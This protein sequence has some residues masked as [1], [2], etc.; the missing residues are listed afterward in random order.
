MKSVTVRVADVLP[1]LKT[2]LETHRK[3]YEESLKGYQEQG[4]EKLKWQLEQM[5]KDSK[6][7]P[8]WNLPLPQNHEAEYQ[9]VIRMFELSSEELVELS[10]QEFKQYVMDEWT[11][12]PGF[13]ST[14]ASY[15]GVK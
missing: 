12:K 10:H 9:Q 1:I 5:T 11:W 14:K 7:I 6:F 13:E 15:H 2:N 4:I 3:D 8:Y